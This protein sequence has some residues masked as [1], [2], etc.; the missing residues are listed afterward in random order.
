[1]CVSLQSQQ[2]H[3]KFEELLSRQEQY[4]VRRDNAEESLGQL[5]AI[6]CLTQAS[7]MEEER[8]IQMLDQKI[9]EMEREITRERK[10][11]GG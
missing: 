3:Q 1:M 7:V 11:M 9:I 6:P 4:K 10:S 5:E 2:V 8:A